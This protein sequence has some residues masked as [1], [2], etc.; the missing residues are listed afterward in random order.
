MAFDSGV[1][2]IEL[3]S[4][5]ARTIGL[6]STARVQTT[7]KSLEFK[8]AVG[9]GA[10]QCNNVYAV[11]RT[12]GSASED[13]DLA[14]GLTDVFGATLTF[15]EVKLFGVYNSG[16]NALTVG[17]ASSN[18]WAGLLNATGTITIPPGGLF[19]FAASDATGAAVVAGTGDLLK[20]AGTSGQ[21]Y[22]LIV[23]GN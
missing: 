7:S 2:K 13:V 10:L 15:A 17:A 3:A 4:W 11:S 16:A 18:A 20:V 12:L 21:P 19:V 5:D 6:S 23:W 8:F 22:E 1:A 9:A 14:G